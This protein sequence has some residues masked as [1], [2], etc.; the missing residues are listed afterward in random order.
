MSVRLEVFI[1]RCIE[2]VGFGGG[3]GRSRTG[4]AAATAG[5]A[6]RD[7][8]ADTGSC[9][10]DLREREHAADVAAGE[11]IVFRM[12]QMIVAVEGHLFARSIGDLIVGTL[13]RT[14]QPEL[15]AVAIGFH[16]H[17]D[18]LQ[19]VSSQCVNFSIPAFASWGIQN[20]LLPI[21]MA[22]SHRDMRSSV[23]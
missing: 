17:D 5:R 3:R 23:S 1:F 12:Q 18:I 8:D 13:S 20:K 21:M 2:Q 9:G 14:I 7:A 11:F 19:V 16:L 6:G 4:A 15:H 22:K 10:L